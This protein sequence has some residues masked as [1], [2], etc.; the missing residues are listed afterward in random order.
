MLDFQEK[1]HVK[2]VIEELENS[3]LLLK[4]E[5]ITHEV[6]HSER[7]NAIIEP[8][9]KKQWFVKM[10]GLA[11]QVLA[12]QKIVKQKFILYQQDMKN[13]EPLDGNYL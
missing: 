4:V 12:N 10:R 9:V 7:T 3:D 8:M 2:K 11:D 5:P 6:G 1:K 13:D